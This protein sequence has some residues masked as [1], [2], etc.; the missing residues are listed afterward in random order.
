MQ[1]K[2]SAQYRQVNLQLA[3]EVG[4]RERDLMEPVE[5]Q[6][7]ENQ[8]DQREYRQVTRGRPPRP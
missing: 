1:Q 7:G 4:A 3:R 5:T 6:L 8:S 2:H